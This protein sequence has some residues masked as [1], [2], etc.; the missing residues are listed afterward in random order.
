[1]PH[2]ETAHKVS[3]SGSRLYLGWLLLRG[4]LM[5]IPTIGLN[6][7]WLTTRKR[8]FYWSNTEIDGDTLEYTGDAGQL[9]TGFLMALVIFIPLYGLFFY[10][11]TQSSQVIIIGYGSVALLVW[12]L[13]GYATYRARDFRLSRTLWR[14]IRFDQTGNAWAYALR[15]FAWSLLNVG[16][17]GLAYPFMAAN[18]W[19]YRYRHTWY[20][21]RPFAFSG[22][23]RQL[24][25]PY[26]PAWLVCAGLAV[27]GLV[28]A[29][30]GGVLD[31]PF[32]ADITVYPWLFALALVIL[33]VSSFYRAVEMSRMFSAV[34]LG[35]ARLTLRLSPLRLIGQ[36]VLFAVGLLAVYLLLA[37]GGLLVM[38]LV[39]APAFAGGEFDPALLLRAM[40]SSV[41]TLLAVVTGYLLIFGAFVFVHELILGYGF[42]KLVVT[43]AAISGVET[44]DGVRARA[45]DKALAGEGLADAL[46]VGGY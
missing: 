29:N 30:E 22:S 44:L 14:G 42:W 43:S 31:D 4:Y 8:R 3:F 5:M 11:S 15:R 6:R 26:Y 7:F 9:L 10:L 23:W 40:Q 33:V 38:G 36:Y 39:A 21:D 37:M 17:L 1:M 32:A 41:V 19:A 27:T 35:G 25:A 20:G 28:F 24:L 45:E 34:S 13:H 18:L 2:L 46:N 16:T 12:F